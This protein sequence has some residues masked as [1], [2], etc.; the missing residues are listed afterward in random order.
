M[1]DSAG[2]AFTLLTVEACHDVALIHDWQM[3]VWAVRI[4]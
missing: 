1:P 2:N 4:G 3:V